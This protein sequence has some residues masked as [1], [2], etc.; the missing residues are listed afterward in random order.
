MTQARTAR[1]PQAPTETTAIA[2]RSAPTRRSTRICS[3]ADSS[4]R[5]ARPTST[6]GRSRLRKRLPCLRNPLDVGHTTTP[7]DSR[8]AVVELGGTSAVTT[9]TQDRRRARIKINAEIAAA[10]DHQRWR[11][12]LDGLCKDA[13]ALKPGEDA[14]GNDSQLAAS[15]D[16]KPSSP[17]RARQQARRLGQ[18]GSQRSPPR[19]QTASS[20]PR[21]T[22]ANSSPPRAT[23][24]SSPPGLGQLQPLAASSG[25][26][27]GS[28][29]AA[30][31]ENSLRRRIAW[32]NCASRCRRAIAL[33]YHDGERYRIAV[34]YVGEGRNRAERRLPRHR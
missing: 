31:G 16:Y 7:L 23:A 15:G 17:P 9:A 13:F 25:P 4:S 30:S 19:A 21:A 2:G 10:A 8:Y 32:I 12:V 28:Q 20:P 26:G 11:R 14:S 27:Y 24:A 33:T 5:S 6:T 22:T 3:A 1:R 18:H 34:A 29:L